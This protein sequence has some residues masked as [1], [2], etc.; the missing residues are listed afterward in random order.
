MD[1]F[2]M[3]MLDVIYQQTARDHARAKN[4]RRGEDDFPV[5]HGAASPWSTEASSVFS[6]SCERSPLLSDVT[7]SEHRKRAANDRYRH[8]RNRRAPKP[9]YPKNPPVGTAPR[10]DE[11]RD[12]FL[13]CVGHPFVRRVQPGGGGQFCL[14]FA[15]FINTLFYQTRTSFSGVTNTCPWLFA[16]EFSAFRH[17]HETPGLS[18]AA[19]TSR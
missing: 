19:P 15:R 18:P 10:Y 11:R 2:W 1:D 14:Q 3:R 4:N 7:G 9:A 12:A 5:V 17:A 8:A 6:K 13:K 16:P